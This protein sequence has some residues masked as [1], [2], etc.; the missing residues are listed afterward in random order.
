ME[1]GMVR[2]HRMKRLLHLSSHLG[3]LAQLLR[4]TLLALPDHLPQSIHY[5]IDSLN[6]F[7]DAIHVRDLDIPVIRTSSSRK[8]S[9]CR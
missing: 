3:D 6:S 8:S 7:D 1:P 2:G 9:A 4:W 5:S